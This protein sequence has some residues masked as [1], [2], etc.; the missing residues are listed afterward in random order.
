MINNKKSKLIAKHYGKKV[1]V[2]LPQDCTID[3]WMDAFRVLMMGVG[4]HKDTADD[5][6]L[7]VGELINDERKTL[8]TNLPVPVSPK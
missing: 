7:E 8:L 2:V 1:A 5:A 3:E 6:I 4:F